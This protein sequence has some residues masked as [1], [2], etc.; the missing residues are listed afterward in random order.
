MMP[1]QVKKRLELWAA[2]AI[3]GFLT[4]CQQAVSPEAGDPQKQ[5]ASTA[6][7]QIYVVN[8]PLQYFAQRIG[9]DQVRVEFPVPSAKD[10]AFFSPSPEIV[11][12][13]QGADLILLNGADYAQWV[14]RATLPGSKLVNTSQ[15]FQDEYIMENAI[16][17]SHGP[18]GEHSHGQIAFTTWL[19]FTLA[20]KQARQV[21]HALATARPE[22]E[23]MWRQRFEDL[24]RDLL[25]LDSTLNRIVTDRRPILGSHPVYQYLARRYRLNLRSVHFE[26]GKYPDERSW[27]EL[28]QL[29]EQHPA[30]WMLWEDHPLER[31]VATLQQLGVKSLVFNPGGNTPK[32][33][34]F[35]DVMRSNVNNLGKVF[36]QDISD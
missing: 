24:E 18:E 6:K 16:T 36:G 28:K 9:G 23:P 25:E 1:N 12:A 27:R 22:G 35:L 5:Q 13:Y 4:A 11:S 3:I 33:G 31:T 29:L 10:P 21:F 20:L 8:Y 30:K 15:P 32:Q 34:D 14:S 7:L 17:H 2:L 26:P 19:D